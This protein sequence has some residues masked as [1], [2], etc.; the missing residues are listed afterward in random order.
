MS[1]RANGKQARHPAR[2]EAGYQ[3]IY[4]TRDRTASLASVNP[5][6]ELAWRDGELAYVREPLGSVVEE[7]LNRYPGAGS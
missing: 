1:S 4:S 7:N 2:A 6:T 5:A 3:L